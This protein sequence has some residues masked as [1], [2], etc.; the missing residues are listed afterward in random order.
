[1]FVNNYST[2]VSSAELVVYF[3]IPPGKLWFDSF[4][5]VRVNVD[6]ELSASRLEPLGA[7]PSLYPLMMRIMV[8]PSLP[9]RY[10]VFMHKGMC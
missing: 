1:M 6:R 10:S 5:H 7:A 4:F 2:L 3:P 8:D 9:L